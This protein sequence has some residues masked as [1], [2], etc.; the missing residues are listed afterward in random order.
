MEDDQFL[1]E[2]FEEQLVGKFVS[3]KYTSRKGEQVE[4]DM[5]NRLAVDTV[6]RPK[7]VVILFTNANNR[8]EVPLDDFRTFVKLLN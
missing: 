5:V 8:R 1:Q 6:T 2:Y 3:I 7:P 4:V